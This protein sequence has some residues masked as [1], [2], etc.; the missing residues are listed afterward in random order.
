MGV[1]LDTRSVFD[2]TAVSFWSVELWCFF[3]Q[4][5]SWLP[6]DNVTSS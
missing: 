1:I 6:A 3:K 4:M 2:L 5:V